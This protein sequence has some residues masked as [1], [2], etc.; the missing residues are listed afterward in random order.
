[1][2]VSNDTIASVKVLNSMKG[3]DMIF[4]IGDGSDCYTKIAD[5][6]YKDQFYSHLYF[7]EIYS[8]E[9]LSQQMGNA[10]CQIIYR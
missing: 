10:V 2:A 7:G 3:G 8:A 1:M 4:V 5:G 6:I 9:A